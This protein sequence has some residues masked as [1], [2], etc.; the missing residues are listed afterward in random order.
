MSP[1]GPPATARSEGFPRVSGDE[2]AGEY[3]ADDTSV[4]F[5]A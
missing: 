4:V 5:P 2:P 1:V 3:R